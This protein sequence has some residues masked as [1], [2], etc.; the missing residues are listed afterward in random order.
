MYHCSLFCCSTHKPQKF[1]IM[2]GYEIKAFYAC[3][4][5]SFNVGISKIFQF[6]ANFGFLDLFF[7]L[8]LF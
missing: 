6:V 1:G 7:S 2:S 8:L 3:D 5:V 4:N